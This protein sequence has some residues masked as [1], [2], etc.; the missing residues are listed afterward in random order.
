MYK[1]CLITILQ[2]K[3]KDFNKNKKSHTIVSLLSLLIMSGDPSDWSWG[4]LGDLWP[5]QCAPTQKP[6]ILTVERLELDQ[7]C[8]I[9]Y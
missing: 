6:K 5:C 1:Y 9:S 7:M 2:Q 8:G 3:K 4:P